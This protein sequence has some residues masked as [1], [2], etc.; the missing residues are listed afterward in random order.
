MART[1]HRKNR[2]SAVTEIN[3]TP[4]IDLAFALLIIFMITTPLLEQTIPLDLPV[5]S[6]NQAPA[7]P[8]KQ[9]IQNLSIDDNGAYYWGVQQ[10]GERELRSLL[11]EIAKMEK[12]PVIHIRASGTILYQEVIVVLDMLKQLEISKISLDTHVK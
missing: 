10:V 8:D 9:E 3:V 4:L 12:P 6:E 1:F 2:L 11:E 7:K 5:E